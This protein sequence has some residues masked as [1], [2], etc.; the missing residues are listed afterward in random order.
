MVNTLR[1]VS[2]SSGTLLIALSVWAAV[3]YGDPLRFLPGV[4]VAATI[5]G[6]PPAL[7]YAKLWSRRG[8]RYLKARRRGSVE[9]DATFVSDDPDPN[10]DDALASI[11]EAVGAGDG[12]DAVRWEP[13]PEGEGL[14]V[15][16]G[17]FHNSFVRLTEGG[18]LVVTGASKRTRT[19]AQFVG[20]LREV[21]MRNRSNNPLLGPIPVRGAPRWFLALALVALLGVGVGGVANAAYP[22]DAYNTPEKTVLVSYDA[23]ADVDPTTSPTEATL[24]KAAFMTGALSEEAVEVAWEKDGSPYVVHDARQAIEISRDVRAQLRTARE[25]SLTPA[26]V[27]R[28]ARIEADLHAAE[29][30]VAAALRERLENDTAGRYADEIRPLRRHLLRLAERPVRG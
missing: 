24:G 19:L 21:S 9:M 10:P 28:A 26:Q 18:R 20:D 3:E 14:M 17:G 13:F 1:A 16:H 8:S 25:G 29:R 2:W 12:S 7:A 30:D 5:L 27:D 23:R 22:T 15:T 11:A 4:V 6:L